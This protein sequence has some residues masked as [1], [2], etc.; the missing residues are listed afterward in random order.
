MTC[1]IFVFLKTNH[2]SILK[3]TLTIEAYESWFNFLEQRWWI[4]N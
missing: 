1:D 4:R 2:R 3:D